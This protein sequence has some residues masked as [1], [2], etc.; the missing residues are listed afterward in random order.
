MN[1]NYLEMMRILPYKVGAVKTTRV[2]CDVLTCC[3]LD[4]L[5][6]LNSVQY[7]GGRDSLPLLIV[8]VHI[9]HARV[10]HSVIL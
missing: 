7:V 5:I 6:D 2:R 9:F 4:P 1:L 3:V 10:L 8:R